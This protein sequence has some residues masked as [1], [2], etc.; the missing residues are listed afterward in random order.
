MRIAI[1]LTVLF[2][3]AFSF[4]LASDSE[5]RPNLNQNSLIA[6]YKE[7]LKVSASTF[8]PGWPA[9]QA[10]DGDPKTSWFSEKGD[11]AALNKQP[12]MKVEFP[13][14]VTI[15]RVTILGNREEAWLKG[16][17]IGVGKIELYDKDGKKLLVQANECGENHLDIDFPLLRPVVGVRAVRFVSL[18]DEGDQN[19]YSDIALGEFQVE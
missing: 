18:M 11:A 14:D 15:R 9:S 16:Y 8:W 10:F 1:P 2:T 4:A 17:T 13:D 5:K 7:K 6:E 3:L 12:W 19:P